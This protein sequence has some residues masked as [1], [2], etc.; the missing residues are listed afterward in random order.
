MEDLKRALKDYGFFNKK[1]LG[2]NFIFDK[3]ILKKL[4]REAKA[5]VWRLVPDRVD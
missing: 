5:Y 3:N 2:Q 1:S 4:L